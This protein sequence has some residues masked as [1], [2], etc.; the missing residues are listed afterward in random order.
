MFRRILVATDLGEASER[1]LG[2][3]H[4]IA[5]RAGAELVLLHVVEPVYQARAWLAPVPEV[6]MALLYE[7]QRRDEREAQRRLEAA[8]ERLGGVPGGPPITATV[9]AGI[10]ADVI[11]SAAHELGADLL[12]VGTHARTGLKHALLGSVAERVVRTAHCPVLI[13]R[14]VP[15]GE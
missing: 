3:G 8:R 14:R 13:A 1:A 9:R 11:P 7:A 5:Q 10:A 6:E 15:R 4:D 2:I 12:V